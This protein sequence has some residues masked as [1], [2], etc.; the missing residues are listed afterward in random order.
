ML[1][2]KPVLRTL[3]CARTDSDSRGQSG[4]GVARSVL[5]IAASKLARYAWIRPSRSARAAAGCAVVMLS[6]VAA[7]AAGYPV[8]VNEE[9]RP[10][11]WL[12]NG[13]TI[14]PGASCPGLDLRHADLRDADLSGADLSGANLTRADLRHANLSGA[15]L[16]GAV[17]DGAD[18]STAF[19]NR[20]RVVG[21]SLRGTNLAFARAA[22]ADFS[23]ADLTAANLEMAMCKGGRFVEAR[24]VGTDLQEAKFYEAD[25]SRA[26]VEGAL[27]R[28]TVWQDAFMDGCDGCPLEWQ[29]GTRVWEP[30]A[31]REPARAQ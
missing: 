24:L 2:S 13:C 5:H 18:L 3:C 21:A 10:D 14:G 7:L 31:T 26:R 1:P 8:I 27:L 6:S 4:P 11:P 30:S 23:H 9:L 12:V 22:K 29:R 20:A 17:L 28:F 15:N 25:F 16:S 19:L